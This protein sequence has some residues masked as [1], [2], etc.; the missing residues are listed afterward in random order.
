MQEDGQT[1]LFLEK[2]YL[3]V[4]CQFYDVV[5]LS[6]RGDV[7]FVDQTRHRHKERD[8]QFADLLDWLRNHQHQLINQALIF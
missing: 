6:R 2:K 3:P 5:Q 4:G 8:L 1:F 7:A